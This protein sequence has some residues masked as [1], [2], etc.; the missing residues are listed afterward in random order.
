MR[1]RHLAFIL[2][3]LA[4]FC[5]ACVSRFG[6]ARG[7]NIVLR[8]TNTLQFRRSEMELEPSTGELVMHW[9]GVRAIDGSPD[10]LEVTY[11]VFDD[12]NANRMPEAAEIVRQRTHTEPSRKVLFAD[13]RYPKSPR[14]RPLS[15][16]LV[17]RTKD[18]LR[19]TVW[20]LQPD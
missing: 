17:A 19:Q 5:S 13:E 15:A 14:P 4:L 12:A 9:V 20:T 18:E 1:S 8:D 16:Q 2:A 3:A 11:I 7:R 10:L 6:W